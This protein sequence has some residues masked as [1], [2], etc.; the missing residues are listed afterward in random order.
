MIAIVPPIRPAL[1]SVEPRVII[2]KKRIKRLIHS[3]F[4][5]FFFQKIFFISKSFQSRGINT[6]RK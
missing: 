4:S 5:H 2:H 6:T 3:D 1:D